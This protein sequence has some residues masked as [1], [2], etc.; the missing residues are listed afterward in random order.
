MKSKRHLANDQNSPLSISVTTTFGPKIEKDR[1]KKQKR[2]TN[3]DE[4]ATRKVASVDRGDE[5]A[6]GVSVDRSKGLE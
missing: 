4:S 6:F 1:K 5:K 3:E 2:G